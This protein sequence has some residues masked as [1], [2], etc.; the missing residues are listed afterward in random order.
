MPSRDEGTRQVDNPMVE[1]A[2][3]L[4]RPGAGLP[5]LLL[6]VLLLLLLMVLIPSTAA[7]DVTWD[8]RT[9]T[10]TEAYSDINLTLDGNLTVSAGGNLTLTDADV[11]VN[12]TREDQ[13][14]IVVEEGGEL[15]L[16]NVDLASA[17]GTYGIRVEGRLEF[18]SGTIHDLEREDVLPTVPRGL[19]VRGGGVVVLTEVVVHNPMGY[20][21]YLNDTAAA[22]VQGGGLH[23]ASTTVRVNQQG[24]LELHDVA[25][26][27]EKATE[28]VALV[29][30][31]AMLA[32]GCTFESDAVYSGTVHNVPVYVLGEEVQAFIDGCSIRTAELAI[33]TGGYLEVTGSTFTPFR[34]RGMPDL[35]AKDAD[36]VL[37]DLDL[38]R[39]IVSGCQ[40]ELWST[41]VSP[42]SSVNASTVLSYGPVPPVSIIS[43]DTTLHHHYWVDFLMLNATGQPKGGIDLNVFNSGGGT[44]VNEAL[45]D[46]DGRIRH[47]PI[48]SWTL[49]GDIKD[50]EPSH[51]VQFAGPSYQ[52]TNLQ[53]YG[54][55]TVV[56][57]DR[58]GSYDLVLETDSVTPSTPA[59]QENRTFNIIV[60]GEVL[61]PYTWNLGSTVMQLYVD[62]EL[63]ES[64]TLPLTSRSDVV[65][66]GLDLEPGTHLFTVVADPNGALDEMNEGGNNELRFFLD[67]AP[68]GGTGDLMDLTVEVVRVID[69][70]GN[71]GDTLLPGILYVDYQ[72][73]AY[74]T[75]LWQR[76]VPVGLYVDDLLD[77]VVRVD[78]TQMQQDYFVFNGQFRPNLAGGEYVIKVVVDPFDEFDEEGEFNNEDSVRLTLDE[79]AVDEPLLDQGCCISLVIFGIIAAISLLTSYAQRKRR[80]EAEGLETIRYPSSDGVG[81][82][83]APVESYVGGPG[84]STA[85]Q[86]WEPVSLDERWRVEQR[87]GAFTADGWE[88]GVADRIITPSKR[89]PPSRERFVANELTCPRCRGHE[90]MGFSDGSAKCQSCKKI[91]YPGRRR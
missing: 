20:A 22:V 46:G 49:E 45:S 38:D 35:N 78:L 25:V 67:V 41:T 88:E 60:D 19:V 12:A 33:I 75:K 72:V 15:W 34:A 83:P 24:V 73:R 59:P 27:A 30:S 82:A 64:V 90:I 51:L 4:I 48:R 80:Q 43:E 76:G 6:A 37:E 69:M 61:I 55:T 36:V 79:G 16:D 18:V 9:V 13:L 70:D 8:D 66:T 87:G 29:G 53:V 89:T 74:N 62:G 71:Q 84:P 2:S 58:L 81:S 44:V 7:E 77:D 47:V 3:P 57:W 1:T 14:H 39:V 85:S 21:L 50:W 40:L 68:E 31:S 42:G 11:L 28:L 65:F 17:G 26:S 32:E 91:F 10:S 63:H 86:D 54:N 52:I 5:C 23:G 56:L